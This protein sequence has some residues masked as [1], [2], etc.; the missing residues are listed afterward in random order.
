VS[1]AFCI[2]DYFGLAEVVSKAF[3]V[4]EVSDCFLEL[5]LSYLDRLGALTVSVG[6]IVSTGLD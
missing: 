1:K 4:I 2:F 5:A 6:L 3:D